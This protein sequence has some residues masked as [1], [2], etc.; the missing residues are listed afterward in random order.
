MIKKI[1]AISSVVLMLV[2]CN[3]NEVVTDKSN[4]IVSAPIETTDK[5]E[6]PNTITEQ[7]TITSIDNDGYVHGEN[8]N[9]LGEGIYYPVSDFV[10]NGVNDISVGDTVD[11]SWLAE[12]YINEDWTIYDVELVK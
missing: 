2:G 10:N 9:G 8:V 11:I 3:H 7:H 5:T 1:I 6:Q 12:D 4:K